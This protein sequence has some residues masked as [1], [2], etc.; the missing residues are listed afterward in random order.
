MA[1]STMTMTVPTTHTTTSSS[2]RGGR[3][4][5]SRSKDD[6]IERLFQW[7]ETAFCAPRDKKFLATEVVEDPDVLDYVFDTV[8]SFTC[9]EGAPN[10]AK[11]GQLLL[12][13]SFNEDANSL[14]LDTSQVE[15]TTTTTTLKPHNNVAAF[16]KE[17]D[18][19][20]YC[21]EH[22]ESYIEA[23]ACTEGNEVGGEYE[24][25][26][27]GRRVNKKSK[28]KSYSNDI[29]A[30]AQAAI[31][32]QLQQKVKR[33]AIQLQSNSGSG[34]RGSWFS[35]SLKGSSKR[36]SS[37]ETIHPIPN[38]ISTKKKQQKQQHIDEEENVQLYFRPMKQH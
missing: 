14:K 36:T 28:P 15:T 26:N 13:D 9:A 4:V 8:E 24:Y 30:R 1:T 22:V 20:D 29:T 19:L 12:V 33:E 27:D 7:G 32:A 18:L 31:E 6:V 2:S 23:H 21:F 11:D 3:V 25:S 34:K 10:Y 17:G 35:K 37:P 5:Q 16:G 38:E